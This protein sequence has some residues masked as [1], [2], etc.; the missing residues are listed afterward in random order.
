M[1]DEDVCEEIESVNDDDDG[2]DS[3]LVMMTIMVLVMMLLLTRTIQVRTRASIF[4]VSGCLRYFSVTARIGASEK[5][6][7]FNI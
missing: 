1:C 3:A 7:C 6:F 2:N 5:R 4:R